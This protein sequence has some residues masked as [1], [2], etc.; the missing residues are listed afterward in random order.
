MKKDY[1]TPRSKAIELLSKK[2]LL[3]T[4]SGRL[5]NGDHLHIGDGTDDDYIPSPT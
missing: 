2:A 4:G 3:F 1:I 5:P